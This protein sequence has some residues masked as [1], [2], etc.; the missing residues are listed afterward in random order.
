LGTT[1]DSA[2]PCGSLLPEIRVGP[3]GRAPRPDAHPPPRWTARCGA[4]S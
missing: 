2:G 1:T 3:Q 4:C